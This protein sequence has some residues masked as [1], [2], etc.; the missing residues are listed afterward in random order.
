[1]HREDARTR[2]ANAREDG[3][4]DGN[5]MWQVVPDSKA[6]AM[7]C[8]KDVRVDVWV[9]GGQDIY[10]NGI[11]RP[12][13]SSVNQEQKDAEADTPIFVNGCGQS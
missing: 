2:S 4:D 3:E 12:F 7:V 8:Y 13:G 5:G 6:K 10:D 11:P 1:M 9:M